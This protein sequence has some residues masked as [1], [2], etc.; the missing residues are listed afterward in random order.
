[1]QL[2]NGLSTRG[3]HLLICSVLASVVWCADTGVVFANENP[4]SR[5]ASVQ[6][7][8]GDMA[9]VLAYRLKPRG[10]TIE[11]MMVALLRLNPDAFIQGNVNLLRYDALLRLP[12]AEEVLS[13]PADQAR[14][15]VRGHHTAYLQ[16]PEAP[17]PAPLPNAAVTAPAPSAAAAPPD[18]AGE[19]EALLE[20]LRTAKTRLHELE[21]NIQELERLTQ[22]AQASEPQ[23]A[24]IG[25]ASAAGPTPAPASM[26]EQPMLPMSWVWLAVAAILAF[27]VGVGVARGRRGETAAPVRAP[28]PAPAPVPADVAAQFKARVGHLDLNLDKPSDNASPTDPS[29]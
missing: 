15:I 1:M 17:A 2:P 27:M 26:A 24:A 5:P 9:S 29:K 14:E 20:R 22:Q 18:G 4:V 13:L 3:Q 12:Q 10:A 16:N 6:V 23:P 21:Q 25:G 19:Q 8:E 7:V 11:Q 28:A